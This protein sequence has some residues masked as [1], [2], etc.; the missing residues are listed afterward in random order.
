MTDQLKA[1]L[2]A[3]AQCAGQCENMLACEREKRQALLEGGGPRLERVLQEQQ[4]AVMS[5]EA[6]E[7]KRLAAQQAAGFSENAKGDEIAAAIGDETAR[8][9]LVCLLERL[10]TAAGQLRELNRT[11]LEIAEKQLQ[12]LG[13]EDHGPTYRPGQQQGDYR[14]G[15]SFEQK[16]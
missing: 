8:R 7:R 6:L 2:S 14:V 12:F 13:R 9:E 5:L 16:I 11:A 10:R 15:G 1:Y 3:T 4:A